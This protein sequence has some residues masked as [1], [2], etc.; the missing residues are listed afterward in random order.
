M[1]KLKHKQM[2]YV[3]VRV[4]PGTGQS[5]VLDSYATIEDCEDRCGAMAQQMKDYGVEGFTFQPQSSCF[6]ER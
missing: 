4:A 5:V 6:Y 2:I 1:K 3:V